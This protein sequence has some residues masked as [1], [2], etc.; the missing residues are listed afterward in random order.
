MPIAVTNLELAGRPDRI[1]VPG[2]YTS[3]LVVLRWAGRPVGQLR[4]PVVNG[5]IPGADLE[6]ALTE[7][8]GAEFWMS[9]VRHAVGWDEAEP[10]PGP[11]PLAS[12]AICTRGRPEFLRRALEAL[13]QLPDLGQ[14]LLVVDNCPPDEAAALVVRDFPGVRYVRENRRGLDAARNRALLEARHP[15]VVFTDDDARVE[16]AWLQT[17]LRNFSDPRVLCVT[18]LTLPAELET[19]AQMLFENYTPFSRGFMRRVFDVREVSPL[20]VGPVGAGANMALRR[21]AVTRVGPFDEA[22]D[23]GTPTRSG[24]DHE[25]FTR[26]LAAGYRIV[27]DPAAVNWHTHR[28]TERELRDTLHGY[29]VGVYAMWTRALLV[30][31][32]FG[33]FKQALLWLCHGQLPELVRSLR[34][35]TRRIPLSYLLAELRGCLSGPAAYLRSRRALEQAL[36]QSSSSRAFESIT[37][38]TALANLPCDP[39]RK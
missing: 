2:G 26:I 15:V 3:A 32:E 22:L 10:G 6:R 30:N 17:L 16:P 29:G 25:M 7:W 14:E 12:V 19:E 27:Y 36:G 21:D 24:G 34:P 11:L 5:S 1:A 4:L 13:A 33:V 38:P 20:S 37:P 39:Y 35:S 31:R 23:G 18:G 9:W 8:S 28:R